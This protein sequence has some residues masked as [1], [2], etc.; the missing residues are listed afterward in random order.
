MDKTY[1]KD[2]HVVYRD[3]EYIIRQVKDVY[4]VTRGAFVE[5]NYKLP[6]LNLD[7]TF[8]LVI[9]CIQGISIHID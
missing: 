6:L 7:E 2:I 1:Y 9:P 5:V 3:D 8:K 4:L